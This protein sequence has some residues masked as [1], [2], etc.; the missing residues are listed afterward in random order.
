MQVKSSTSSKYGGVVLIIHRQRPLKCVPRCGEVQNGNAAKPLSI[1]KCS[2]CIDGNR[3]ACCRWD[4]GTILF[5]DVNVSP[6]M[7]PTSLAF[8]AAAE[9]GLSHE[10]LLRH[11]ITTACSRHKPREL[12]WLP[13]ENIADAML[14]PRP[15]AEVSIQKPLTPCTACI[16]VRM[17]TLKA[18]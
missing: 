14:A 13:R 17:K 16:R 15:P 18:M 11:L 7:E 8:Q 3:C 6:S 9:S 12:Q 10:G 1:E 5:T 4:T 2:I